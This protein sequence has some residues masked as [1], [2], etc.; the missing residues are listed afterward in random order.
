MSRQ[1][2]KSKKDLMRESEELALTERRV[3]LVLSVAL[4]LASV[5]SPVFGVHGAFPMTTG[6]GAALSML[7]GYR[8]K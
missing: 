4:A 8:R 1:Q 2:H 6:L 3:F 5:L 7:S